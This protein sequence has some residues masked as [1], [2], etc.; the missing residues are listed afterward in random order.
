MFEMFQHVLATVVALGAAVYLWRRVFTTLRPARG[1][2]G[3]ASCP[4]N[5]GRGRIEQGG[6]APLDVIR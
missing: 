3:C 5:Q 2:G 6:T 4:S 1:A